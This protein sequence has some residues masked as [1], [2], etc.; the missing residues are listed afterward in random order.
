M[1]AENTS[2]PQATEKLEIPKDQLLAAASSQGI[3]VNAP[4]FDIEEFWKKFQEALPYLI[5]LWKIFRP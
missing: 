2:E 4:G 3:D 5:A 1:D